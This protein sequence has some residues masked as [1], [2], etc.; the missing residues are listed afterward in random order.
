MKEKWSATMTI[1]AIN[2]AAMMISMVLKRER[3]TFP[4]KKRS[5]QLIKVKQI[6]KK[7]KTIPA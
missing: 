7:R 6:K 4:N 3:P 5:N 1:L 2:P